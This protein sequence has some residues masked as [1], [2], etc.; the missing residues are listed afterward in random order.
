MENLRLGHSGLIDRLSDPRPDPS[1]VHE[2]VVESF[3][4]DP[5][6]VLIPFYTKVWDACGLKYRR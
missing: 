4:I 5:D 1:V 3:D 2:Q 6:E